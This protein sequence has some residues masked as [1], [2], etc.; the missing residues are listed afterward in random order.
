M[1]ATALRRHGTVLL[2]H[3]GFLLLVSALLLV[4]ILNVPQVIGADQSYVV[5]SDSMEPTYSAGD[6]VIIESVSP[7][8]IDEGD[9]ITFYRPNAQDS[10]ITHRVIDIEQ[11]EQQ[12]YFKTKGDANEETDAHSIPA[13]QVVGRVWFDIPYV[14]YGL[15]FARSQAGI[16]LLV[17]VPAGLLILAEVWDL[18]KITRA[19]SKKETDPDTGDTPADQSPNH[20]EGE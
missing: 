9:V 2:N 6:V 16:A 18:V 14:G 7:E 5:L 15:L 17:M 11:R 1:D 12:L 20:A 8:E 4:L 3:A 19:S 10:R 13:S